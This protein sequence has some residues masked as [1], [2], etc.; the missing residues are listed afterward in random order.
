MKRSGGIPRQFNGMVGECQKCN[1]KRDP[2][3]RNHFLAFPANAEINLDRY[4]GVSPG[5]YLSPT[6]PSRKNRLHTGTRAYMSK[7]TDT[8]PPGHLNELIVSVPEAHILVL[9]LNRPKFMNAMTPT[10]H[11]DINNLLNWFDDEPNLWWVT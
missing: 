3:E 2:H 7:H 11:N 6:L 1:E 5:Y 10:L 9:A 4:T 8:Q